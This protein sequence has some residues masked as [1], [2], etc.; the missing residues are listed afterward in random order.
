MPAAFGVV[1]TMFNNNAVSLS[2]S[3]DIKLQ[4]L[5]GILFNMVSTASP[6]KYFKKFVIEHST[7]NKDTKI[8]EYKM[9]CEAVADCSGGITCDDSTNWQIIAPM[10]ETI[11]Y[12]KLHQ[13]KTLSI[14]HSNLQH[15][16]N[17]KFKNMN[18]P[19]ETR[20]LYSSEN[21]SIQLRVFQSPEGKYEV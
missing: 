7:Y 4:K 19:K 2:Y 8:W 13:N 21:N 17:P 6:E 10:V 1:P 14:D 11:V 18:S 15:W 3:Y 16:D 20:Q 12:M 5:V 9:V